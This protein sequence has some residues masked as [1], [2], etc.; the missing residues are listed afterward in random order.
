MS[1]E[2]YYGQAS[3]GPY[4]LLELGDWTLGS[5]QVIHD[6]KLAVS[7]HGILNDNRDNVVLVPTWYSGSSRH[8]ADTYI[9]EGRALDPKRYFI[10]VANQIGGGLSTSPNN[11]PDRTEF[12]STSISDD[13]R[14]QERAL[15]DHFGIEKLA[16]I[17]GAS[18]GG[19]QGFEWAVRYPMKVER[20]AVLA[21]TPLAT[22]YTKFLLKGMADTLTTQDSSV[23]A[24]VRRHAMWWTTF[25][26]SPDFLR[27]ED[28]NALGLEGIDQ[29]VEEFM[30]PYFAAMDPRVL[31]AM[32]NKAIAA[33]VCS[34][35]GKPVDITLGG[36]TANTLVMS[37]S[38]DRIF[39]PSEVAAHGKLIPSC[40]TRELKSRHG[41]LA[42]FGADPD[43]LLSLDAA[44]DSL[45]SQD[46]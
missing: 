25:G 8:V 4:E 26:W 14:A 15:S 46:V 10:V 23:D 6:C 19:Q 7:T 31:L 39:P 5:G 20:L 36:V 41:H 24:A 44:L 2:T 29:F 18:M 12:P 45:L 37:I 30:V 22:P 1:D 40:T 11:Y 34:F 17:F 32:A 13:V 9:G 3:L 28:Y 33:D 27:D 38:E 43:F 21:A 16:M 42:I 35:T